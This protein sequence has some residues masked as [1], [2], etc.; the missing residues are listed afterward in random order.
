MDHQ[1]DNYGLRFHVLWPLGLLGHK[2]VHN[3]L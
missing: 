3:Y 2:H 1:I